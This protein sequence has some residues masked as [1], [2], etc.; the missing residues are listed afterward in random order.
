MRT[1]GQTDITKLIGAFR[2]YTNALTE[3]F[4]HSV[5]PDQVWGQLSF[6]CSE[7]GEGYFAGNTDA[8]N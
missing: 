6:I 3:H 7:Q 5:C 1:D 8:E 4:S 2:N